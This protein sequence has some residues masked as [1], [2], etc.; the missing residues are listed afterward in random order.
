MT[1]LIK[2]GNLSYFQKQDNLISIENKSL[3]CASEIMQT[4][5]KIHMKMK[6]EN[7]LEEL[8]GIIPIIKLI[9]NLHKESM[10]VLLETF[11]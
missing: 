3:V 4:V 2:A 8:Q 10:S 1:Y 5:F 6:F 7:L 9:C 11:W